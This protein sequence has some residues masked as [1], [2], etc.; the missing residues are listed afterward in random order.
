[1][2]TTTSRTLPFL[3]LPLLALACDTA[4]DA[5]G[6]GLHS[7]VRD[8]AGITI[9]DSANPPLD[10][11]LPWKIAAQPSLSIGSIDSGGADELFQVTD[12]MR[13]A[14]GR[15]VIANSGSN[16]LRAFNPDG[17]HAATFGGQGEGPG[18]FTSY[19]PT[20]VARWP[21]DSIAAPNPWGM[22]VSLFDADGNHGR[23]LSVSPPLLDVVDLL[24]DGK[25]VARARGGL[26]ATATGS[27]GI[28]RSEDEW[29]VLAADGTPHASLGEFLGTEWWAT[30]NS[31]GS[32]AGGRPHPY[33]RGTMGSVWG[34]MVAIGTSDRY[35]IRA[36]SPD[37][38][39]ARI[40]RRDVEL[41][42]PSRAVLDEYYASRYADLPDE[43]RTA[44][45]NQVRGMPPVDSYPAFAGIM[46]DRAGYLWV[47]EY[48]VPEA[49]GPVWSVFD[50]E[51][52][53]QGLVETPPGLRLF[54]IGEDYLL[55]WK[56]DELGVEHVEVWAV[57]RTP[58]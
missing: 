14:D 10:S 43:E 23:D 48:W 33:S 47:R 57:S 50:P 8:S 58:T 31:D 15:I 55:G 54:E 13:L 4:D 20:A 49:E 24:P 42:S 12:A 30:F 3:A 29:G 34:E 18:E 40:V 17:S 56:Y 21:G 38:A 32:I 7:A 22:R 53:V 27:T 35:E 36:F 51:G 2:T 16:E 1:M 46:S 37:G 9:V 11:R 5:T 52:R 26:S 6:D 28:V 41:E 45:L 44:A 39:L 25:I 19:S